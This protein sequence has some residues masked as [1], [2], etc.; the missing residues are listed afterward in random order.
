MAILYVYRFTAETP[1]GTF[2]TESD[3]DLKSVIIVADERTIGRVP[4]KAEPKVFRWVETLAEQR[5]AVLDAIAEGR[6]YH[7]QV[8]LAPVTGR[9]WL[10]DP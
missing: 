5:Q 7:R 10:R 6:P 9:K 3:R 8:L 2:V 4:L 1:C